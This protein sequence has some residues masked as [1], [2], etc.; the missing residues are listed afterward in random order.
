[1]YKVVE[2]KTHRQMHDFAEFPNKL[3]KGCLQYV[4]AFFA[5]EMKIFSDEKNPYSG[6]SVSKY[7][8]C[9]KNKKIVGRIGGIIANRDNVKTGEKKIR[10]TRFDA[11]DDVEVAKLLFDSVA[12]FGKTHGM[13]KLH[14]PLGY[15]DQER[16][17]MVISGYENRVTFVNLYNYD[18]YPKLMRELGFEKEVDYHEFKIYI[19]KQMIERFERVSKIVQKR[20][21]VFDV[22]EEMSVSNVLKNYGDKFFALLD[23]CYSDLHGY[24]PTDKKTRDSMI[25][26]FKIALDKRFVSILRD[27][28]NELVALGV[29]FPSLAKSLQKYGGRMHPIAMLSMLSEMKKPEVVELGLIAVRPDMK[30]SG[31]NAVVM[32][33]IAKNVIACGIE[34]VESN[35]E[36]EYNANV[37]NLWKGFKTENHRNRRIFVREIEN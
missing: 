12:T 18:Y 6:D 7:F 36:L 16:E 20:T 3:Y 34:Y 21:P 4:P 13:Q 25:K 24:M 10:F 2:V 31:V 19:E 28:N 8:L 1:M 29:A 14:G 17:G 33:K 5:D 26:S 27:E 35:A 15:N 23:E 11:I 37:Q 22:L 30:N 9:Y 32:E